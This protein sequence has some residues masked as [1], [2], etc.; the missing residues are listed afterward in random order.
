MSPSSTI[1]SAPASAAAPGGRTLLLAPPSLAAHEDE[2]RALFAAFDRATS[3]LQMLDRLAAGVVALPPTAYGAVLLLTRDDG[4][5]RPEAAALLTRPV[6]ARVAAA[7]R[8]GARLAAQDG[9]AAVDA[10]EALLA[11]L[12]P[13]SAPGEYIR[14][15]EEEEAAV[16]LRFGAKKNKT[17]G[18]VAAKNGN[19]SAAPVVAK[20]AAPVVRATPAGVGFVDLDDDLDDLGEYESGDELVPEDELLTEEERNRPVPKGM[21]PPP[22]P[23]SAVDLLS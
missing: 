1:P 22:S 5:R 10:R 21:L 17:D 9:A 3:D 8:P 16:P 15:D 6:L 23:R 20:P 19:G 11:G 12:A 18:G 7:M 2:L 4:A 14:S 13:G